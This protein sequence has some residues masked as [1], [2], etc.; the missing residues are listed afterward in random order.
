[1]DIKIERNCQRKGRGKA[2]CEMRQFRIKTKV[3]DGLIDCNRSIIIDRTRIEPSGLYLQNTLKHHTEG[4]RS[5]F[6]ELLPCIL[7]S[8]PLFTVKEHYYYLELR[9]LLSQLGLTMQENLSRRLLP[10]IKTY[11]QIQSGGVETVN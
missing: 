5:L 7:A 10:A 6:L 2:S 1:M 9:L 8:A 4:M 11:Y 3:H